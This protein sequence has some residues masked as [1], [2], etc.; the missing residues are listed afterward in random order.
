MVGVGA[1][2]ERVNEIYEG[3]TLGNFYLIS[4]K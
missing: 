2:E 3:G 1:K 4:L